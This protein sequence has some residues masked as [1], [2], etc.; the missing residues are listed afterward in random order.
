MHQRKIVRALA[1]AAAGFGLAGIGHAQTQGVTK[2]EIVVGSLQDLSGPIAN[3]GKN[4]RNG[5]QMRVDE[6]NAAGGIH[7]RKLRLVVEDHGYDPKKAL[8][9]AQKLVQK[10]K[11]FAMISTVGTPTNMAAIPVLIENNVPNLFALSAGQQMYEPLHKLKYGYAPPYIDQV[12]IGLRYLVKEKGY[13]RI[14]A[15]YQDDDFG[16]DVLKGYEAGLKAL[17]MQPTEKTSYKRGATD[18]SS[19]VAKLRSANCELVVLGAVVREPVAIMTEAKKIGWKADFLGTTATNS[20]VAHK[21]GGDAVEG[22]YAISQ[23]SL[24]YA[25]DPSPAIRDWVAR[26]KAK[27]GDDPDTYSVWGY[28]GMNLFVQTAEKTGPNLT[29]DTFLDTLQSMTFPRDI[30]GADFKYSKTNHLGVAGMRVQQ[31]K[32]GRWVNVTDIIK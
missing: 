7:G 25:D 29:L 1:I 3:F 13:K 4:G 27:F 6:A 10:D 32:G 15:L 22:L 26:Y 14:C 23:F 24:P 30:F 18:F 31:I 5:L 12:V 2:N 11:I 21:L 8:L 9:G 16:Q 28:I 20:A 19:Q 17:N